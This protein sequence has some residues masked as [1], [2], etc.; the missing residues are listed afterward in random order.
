ML[1]MYLF[2]CFLFVWGPHTAL[3][4]D[5]SRLCAQASLLADF[6]VQNTAP[7]IKGKAGTLPAVH[8]SS[9]PHL[10]KENPY[11]ASL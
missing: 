3:L 8:L 4:R 2:V 11:S 7:E 9:A 6:R 10:F 1:F 5:Y